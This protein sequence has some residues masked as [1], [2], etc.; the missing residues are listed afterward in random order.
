M[1]KNL[2]KC[3]CILVLQGW[4][5]SG[6]IHA[7][8]SPFA[9]DYM[10]LK[11]AGKI[12]VDFYRESL[13]HARLLAENDKNL[14]K[15]MAREFYESSE[16]Y[17]SKLFQSG[18]I[19]LN[20]A[21]TF[22][23][24][25]VVKKLLRDEPGLQNKVHVYLAR[26]SSAN[27]LTFPDGTIVVNVGLLDALSSEGQL[28]FV[29]AHEVAH[30]SQQHSAKQFKKVSGMN[31]EDYGANSDKSKLFLGLR[32]S[33]EAEMDADAM[34][35]NMMV[36]A[37]YDVKQ[38]ATALRALKDESSSRVQPSQVFDP[39]TFKS[40]SSWTNARAMDRSK[41][42]LNV[43]DKP[44]LNTEGIDDLFD[45][46]PDL[47]KRIEA[48][49]VMSANLPPAKVLQPENPRFNFIRATAAFER[50]ENYYADQDFLNSLRMALRLLK[51]YPSSA[52]LKAAVA[53][54]LYWISYYK[55]I[56][57]GHL[58]FDIERSENMQDLAVLLAYFSE[59][60][61]KECKKLTYLWSKKMIEEYPGHEEVIFYNAVATSSYLGEQAARN[62]YKDYYAR[63]P[64]GRY[65]QFVTGKLQ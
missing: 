1:K 39:V 16:Y 40:D 61:L 43:S 44:L 27:A 55:E 45:T 53:R 47:D 38:A 63:F 8:D 3:I 15:Q 10:P 12:P 22:Y 32:Y 46:H 60:P 24:D 2:L 33:R 17:I 59:M 20:N 54:D 48:V 57:E 30:F 65:K 58:N 52:Y 14:D 36:Q 50:V 51:T 31:S 18:Q 19:Y 64:N 49:D 29:L 25:S 34:A 41:V 5:V 37:G 42:R 35:L 21:L 11:S 4:T 26:F 28:A 7:Q 56:A 13:Q 9:S 62:F 23:L 6:L